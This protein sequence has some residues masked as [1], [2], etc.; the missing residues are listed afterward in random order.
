MVCAA[1]LTLFP[2][3]LFQRLVCIGE[4]CIRLTRVQQ[5]PYSQHNFVPVERFGDEIVRPEN[6]RSLRCG[7]I[8]QCRPSGR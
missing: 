7:Q 4:V 6:Q 8:C 3:S 1:E 5:V 2:Q